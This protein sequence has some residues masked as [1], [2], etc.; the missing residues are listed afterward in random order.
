MRDTGRNNTVIVNR[1]AA[2]AVYLDG[3]FYGTIN[4]AYAW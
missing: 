4:A 1:T 2:C 3:L